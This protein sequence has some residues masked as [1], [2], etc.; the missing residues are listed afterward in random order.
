PGTYSAFVQKTIGNTGMLKLLDGV[1]NRFAYFETVVSYADENDIK[2][3]S[4]RVNGEIICEERGSE[5]FGYDPIFAVGG[6]S[7]SELTIEEKNQVSHRS[8]ALV[9]F[10]DWYISHQ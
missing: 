1:A 3:F 4:G 8:R 5:G 10:Q 9:A 7:F 6:K 2:T